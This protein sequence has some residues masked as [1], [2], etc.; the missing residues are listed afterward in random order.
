MLLA[1]FD[2]LMKKFETAQQKLMGENN[3]VKLDVENNEVNINILENGKL[4]F[5]AEVI[6]ED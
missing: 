5:K 6:K 1:A 3:K 4:D 2:D